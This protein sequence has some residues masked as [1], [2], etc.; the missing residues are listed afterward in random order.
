MPCVRGDFGPKNSFY[1]FL[2]PVNRDKMSGM[3]KRFILGILCL[4]NFHVLGSGTLTIGQFQRINQPVDTNV[5]NNFVQF[6]FDNKREDSRWDLVY[7]ASLRQYTGDRGLLYSVPEAYISRNVGR[8]EFTLGRKVISWQPN[9]RFWAMGEINSLKNFNLLET[10][11]EG[12]FGLHFERKTKNMSFILFASG[13]NVPQVNP[14]FKADGGQVVGKNEWSNPPP[15][16]V[17]FRE[18]E[19]PVSYD[20]IY[21]KVSEIALKE[22][23]AAKFSIH[24]DNQAMTFHG[25]YK[26]EPGIRI[27]ATGYYEQTDVERAVV[28]AKPFVN[29]HIFWG[30]SYSYHLSGRDALEGSSVH[31]AYDS[32]IPNRGTD[33]A[34]DQF[35]SLKIQ[36]IYERV[37]YATASLKN[38]G[39]FYDLSLNGLY[40]IEGD[41]VNTNV[42]AK[43]PRWRQAIG[44]SLG[45]SITD[46]FRLFT[47]Y[48]YD[49]KTQDMAFL[50][51]TNYQFS[52][53]IGIGVD[54]QV[55]NAPDDNSFWAPFR[56]NDSFLG[57]FS[58]L[59]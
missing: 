48:K 20:V 11:R 44:A 21:P 41:S 2:T 19:V 36:P 13:I 52:R 31:V 32:I 27:V 34:F 1:A 26:P 10:D 54:L 3:I 16:F 22:A 45:W 53:H 12:L 17:R 7:N 49:I 8:S 35:D 30:S 59:F 6:D 4:V 51:R 38:K 24:N 57:H 58:Y 56:S 40:L 25:G 55:I 43:K 28:Q 37:S 46:S 9:D 18:S 5:D 29:S 47:D 14:T 33:T 23:A 42:F 15:R 50:T 39:R